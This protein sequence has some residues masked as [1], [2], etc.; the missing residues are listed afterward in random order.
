MSDLASD[1]HH[2]SKTRASS[3]TIFSWRQF[4][5][6]FIYENLPPVL[7]SPIAALLFERSVARA[8][9]VCQHRNLLALSTHYNPWGFIIYSWLIVYPASWLITAGAVT[10][11][12]APTEAL[13]MIDPLQMLCAYAF[14]FCRRLIVSVKYGYFDPSEFYALSQPAPEWSFAKGAQKLIAIGWGKPKQF[15]GLIASELELA[16]KNLD[17]TLASLQLTKDQGSEVSLR[18]ATLNILDEAYSEEVPKSNNPV[19]LVSVLLILVSFMFT[20]WQTGAALLGATI[21]MHLINLGTYASIMAGMGIMGFGLICAFDFSRRQR[22]L[23]IL[24]DGLFA[25]PRSSDDDGGGAGVIFDAR[26][27]ND[28]KCW[29]AAREVIRKFGE[30]YYLRVQSYTSILL[31][32]SFL[33]VGF[34]NFLAWTGTPH[35]ISTV[36]LLSSTVLVIA[37]IGTV[38]MRRAILL[39]EQSHQSRSR[40]LSKL[41][42]E[43][44]QA[45]EPSGGISQSSSALDWGTTRIFR[46]MD[47]NLNFS[48]TIFRPTTVLGYKADTDLISSILGI[49]VTGCLL[50]I[51]GFAETG[52]SYSGVGWLVN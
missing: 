19:I 42:S 49:L 8:W 15:P 44:I 20:K 17:I 14:L 10:A 4:W 45:A 21:E 41:L 27:P 16:E 51:Q 18:D 23:E 36:V 29:I 13:G 6:S 3:E 5:I 2:L 47:A 43:E 38:A 30:R 48:E 35:H 40:L 7:I 1:H 52:F 22:A 28:L 31:C 33:C 24:D 39:Q 25:S 50:A 34:L 32:F 46:Q 12:F 9:H 11:I 26:S 37:S